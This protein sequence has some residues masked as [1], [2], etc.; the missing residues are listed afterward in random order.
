ML[1]HLW[2]TVLRH[3]LFNKA[4][5]S[6]RL[7]VSR[8]FMNDKVRKIFWQ[9]FPLWGI[10]LILFWLFGPVS[11][12]LTL[13][14]PGQFVT[15][16]ST[17]TWRYPPPA[18]STTPLDF[19]PDDR[20]DLR[21]IRSDEA[22]AEVAKTLRQMYQLPSDE[23]P[24]PHLDPSVNEIQE[25]GPV[26]K[27]KF[28]ANNPHS[29]EKAQLGK[30]LFFDGRLS[31]TQQMSCASC[32]IAEL[33]WSDGRSRSLGHGA[34]QLKRNTPSLLNAGHASELFWDGRVGSIEE[35]IVAVLANEN[36][37]ATSP[38]EI[39]ATLSNIE[40]YPPLF[41][42][43]FNDPTP[44]Q[45]RVAQAIATYVRTITSEPSADFDRFLA[46]E[47][48]RLSDSA[49]R[50]LH[51]FR[52]DARCINC[53]HGP[54]LTDQK[55]HNIGLVYFG[56]KYEDRGRYYVT[57]KAEDVGRFRTPGLRNI[58]RTAPYTHLGFFDLP[59]LIN[60]Y[61]AGG[62]RPKPRPHV[63]DS[64]LLPET[65][66]MLIPLHLNKQDKADLLAFLLSLTERR[67]R[68]LMPDLP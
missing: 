20:R 50:G 44:T 37:M 38:Q 3:S 61:N 56:R 12:F 29:D 63:A 60:L 66:T 40:G 22:Y 47:T 16:E 65:S 9:A 59:G 42:K 6:T 23:W 36:E 11:P 51:L 25:L 58:E 45:A 2:Q 28:P 49:I 53:H 5:H 57:Q 52:T 15:N 33:G 64:P 62:S 27:A 48:D 34:H 21:P 32:H 31:R 67:R 26:P 18:V 14:K 68:D 46:G 7:R 24:K 17:T 19:F 55:F 10:L 30:M 1:S 43:A 39:Q 54:Q 35:L 8:K 41:Q 4:Q 13:F